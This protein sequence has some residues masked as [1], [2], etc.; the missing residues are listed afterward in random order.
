MPALLSAAMSWDE[1]RDELRGAVY[2][3]DGIAV[4]K[5]LRGDWP[6]HALQLIGDGVLAALSQAFRASESVGVPTSS[7]DR[8]G[9]GLG[10][11]A[12]LAS[13]A[14]ATDCRVVLDPAEHRSMPVRPAA[15][16][17]ISACHCLRYS[18]ISSCERPMKFHHIRISSSSGTPPSSTNRAGVAGGQRQCAGA[19]RQIGQRGAADRRTAD[20]DLTGVDQHAVLEVALQWQFDRHPRLQHQFGAEQRGVD[21]RR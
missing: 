17:A 16:A 18:T 21:G 5:L 12:P 8:L 9:R 1:K 6:E 19:R 11:A 7:S 4:T 13:P 14:P 3:A 10:R 20:G 15:K 2:R